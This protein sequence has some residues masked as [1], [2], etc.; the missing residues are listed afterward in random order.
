[1]RL[2]KETTFSWTLFKFEKIIPYR[3]M[4]HIKVNIYRKGGNTIVSAIRLLFR[5][6][7][8]KR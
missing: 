5:V 4:Y 6:I 7:A 2:K 3:A 8:D 1:M